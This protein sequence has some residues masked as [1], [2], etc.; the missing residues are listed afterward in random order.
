[1]LKYVLEDGFKESES[2]GAPWI[3]G[4]SYDSLE[5]KIRSGFLLS[6]R[7]LLNSDN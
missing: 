4:I 6:N 1:M 7:I 5:S 2:E 3:I